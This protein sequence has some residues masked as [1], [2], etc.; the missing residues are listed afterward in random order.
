[1]AMPAGENR[2]L[3][4]KGYGGGSALVEVTA[5]QSGAMSAE[6]VWQSS[7]VLKTKFTHACVLGDTAYGI[8]NGSLEAV[9]L[10]DGEQ[11]WKQSR[12]GRFGQ[13]QLLLVGDVLIA[14]SET[15]E[16]ALVL[17]TPE[18]YRELARIPALESKTWNVPTIAGRHLLVRNDRQ[19]ICFFL[20]ERKP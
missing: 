13:G 18:E 4:G 12:R 15:G 20:P 1:M 10:G 17:A 9:S 2:F 5:D 6:A 11:L 19:A 8:S 3:I 16:V 14:Q 7:E